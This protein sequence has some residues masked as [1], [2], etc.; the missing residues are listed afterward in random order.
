VV[1]EFHFRVRPVGPL[2]FAGMMLYPRAVAPEL[3][4]FYRDFMADAPDDVGGAVALLTAPPAEFIPEQ[5]RGKAV[6]GVIVFYAGDAEHGPAAFRPMLEWGEP[7]LAQVGPMPYVAVQQLLDPSYPWG[8]KDYSKVD[9]LPELP[10]EA[11]DEMVRL[12][13]LSTSPFSAVILCPLGGAC[14]RIDRASMALNIPDTRWMYFCEADTFD[15]QQQQVEIAW[16]KQFLASMRPWSVGQAPPNFLEPDEG[17]R[18]VRASF[19]D[20]K[21]QRLVALKDR[22]DPENVF[23]RNVNIRP[24]AAGPA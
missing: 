2:V 23:R 20:E 10:D 6:C 22:Y 14:S 9:Y 8:I 17:T 12:A 1:T 19:G 15:D 24:S 11:V 7:V 21:F 13:A 16:A 5:A 3:I 18:R 4:R